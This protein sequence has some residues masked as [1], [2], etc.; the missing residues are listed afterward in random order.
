[1]DMYISAT[2]IPH[3]IQVSTNRSFTDYAIID[4]SLVT[5]YNTGWYYIKNLPRTQQG[6]VLIGKTL[7]VKISYTDYLATYGVKF[8]K[9]GYK[10]VI[11][12]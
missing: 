12:G 6:N 2:H 11:G 1:M 8:V 4:P 10:E 7:F 5:T 9:T 3:Q